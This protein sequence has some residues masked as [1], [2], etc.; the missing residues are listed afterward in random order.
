MKQFLIYPGLLLL[1]VT[2][3]FAGEQSAARFSGYMFGDY[4]W[5]ASH[6][7]AEIQNS[8]GFWFRRIYFTYDHRISGNLSAR[9]RLE[10]NSRGDFSTTS[11]KL[12]PYIKDA[13]LKW[14]INPDHQLVLGI[15]SPPTFKFIEDFWGFRFL[16]KTP[17]D[18]QRWGPSREFGLSAMGTLALEGKL[19]YHVMLGNGSG[20]KSEVNPGKKLMGAIRYFPVKQLVLEVY[21]DWNDNSGATD[22]FTYQGFAGYK[23]ER[24]TLGFLYSHQTRCHEDR[25]DENLDLASIFLI[26]HTTN[27]L[28]IVGRVDRQFDPNSS[29]AKQQY[30]PFD[31][32][33]KSTFFLTGI[34]FR[35]HPLVHLMPNIEVILYDS[36][37]A[38]ITPGTDVLPRVTFFYVFQ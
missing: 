15:S 10:M 25:P 33:S 11:S 21:S 9:M 30:L 29:A 1:F 37:D 6:H 32:D 36:N 7:R 28:T 14:K 5:V 23:T 3:I 2:G 18:L 26:W 24:L 38:G 31:P 19:Q 4:Y 27:Q 16:E 12:I 35:P 17:L 22:W 20:N 34:D 13:Y 8:N